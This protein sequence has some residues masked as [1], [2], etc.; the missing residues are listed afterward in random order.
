MADI[1]LFSLSDGVK[2][3][4]SKSVTLEKDLQNIIEQN[5]IA[6]FGIT[7]LKSEFSN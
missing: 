5:M 6:F 4:P 3:L 7:F 1:N 2:E